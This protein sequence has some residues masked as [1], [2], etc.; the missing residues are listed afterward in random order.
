MAGGIKLIIGY[1]PCHTDVVEKRISFN[2]SPECVIQ[3]G[4]RQNR[5]LHRSGFAFSAHET[6]ENAV[7]KGSRFRLIIVFVNLDR[8]VDCRTDRDVAAVE[9]LVDRHSQDSQRAAG[10]AGNPCPSA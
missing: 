8:A 1:L 5:F 2:I 4:N 10:N 3:L 7:D 6:A 9:N